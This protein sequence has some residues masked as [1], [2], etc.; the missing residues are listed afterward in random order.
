MAGVYVRVRGMGA[1]IRSKARRWVGVG[2]VSLSMA[3]PPTTMVSRVRVARWSIRSGKLRR[4]CWPGPALAAAG[5]SDRVGAG[6]R[7]LVGEGQR[8]P[9]LV[10]VP[11]EIAGE[12]ADQ[13]VAADSVLE[14]VAAGTSKIVNPVRGRRG[15]SF[16]ASPPHKYTTGYPAAADLYLGWDESTTRDSLQTARVAAGTIGSLLIALRSPAPSGR[17]DMCGPWTL[18]LINILP[19]SGA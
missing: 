16:R 1:P 13:H 8:R 4:G 14:P 9:G 18:L 11:G 5:W 17:G 12:H 7:V 3:W 2:V 19:V 6:G 15:C 10:Q